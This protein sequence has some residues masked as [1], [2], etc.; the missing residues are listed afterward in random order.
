MLKTIMDFPC[1]VDMVQTRDLCHM[2]LYLYHGYSC[3]LCLHH[4]FSF[5]TN[6][7]IDIILA[8]RFLVTAQ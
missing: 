8:S 6:T 7:L 5:V 2:Y 4:I 3:H 1:G